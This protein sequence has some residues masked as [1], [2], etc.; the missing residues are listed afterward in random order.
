LLARRCKRQYL[1]NFWDISRGVL[2]A[3]SPVSLEFRHKYK[4]QQPSCELEKGTIHQEG[5]AER[6]RSLGLWWLLRPST[7]DLDSQL[8][9]SLGKEE[10][11]NVI[12]PPDLK[13]L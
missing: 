2:F 4:L 6:R 1:V 11:L 13:I 10:S 12:K 7:T 8:W 9:T 3:L 5:E